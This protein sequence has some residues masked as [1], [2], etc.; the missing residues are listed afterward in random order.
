MFGRGILKS[1]FG[2]VVLSRDFFDS[3]WTRAEAQALC[4]SSKII[5]WFYELSPNDL[6][7]DSLGQQISSIPGQHERPAFGKCPKSAED[8]VVDYVPHLFELLAVK[9]GKVS[10]L[11]DWCR[12]T[13]ASQRAELFRLIYRAAVR[14]YQQRHG[15]VNETAFRQFIVETGE[16]HDTPIL[17]S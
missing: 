12:D 9:S 17:V 4:D 8:A 13:V 5:P 7:K 11:N 14:W 3:K 1:Q 2:L 10:F 16:K 15:S 6:P